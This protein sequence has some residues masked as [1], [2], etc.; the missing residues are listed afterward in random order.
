MTPKPPS[1][2]AIEP[3]LVAAATGDAGAA[4]VRRVDEH[5]QRCASCRQELGRYRAIDAVSREL[6][7]DAP[8]AEEI[9]ASRSAL[10]AR[11]ADLK[12]RVLM[13]GIV[14]SPLGNILVARSEHGVSLVE[15]LG[16][17]TTLAAS[18]LR[19]LADVETVE[20]SAEIARLR[21]DLLEF[22]AGRRRELGWRLDL[23]LAGSDFRRAV[24][25]AAAG[26]PYGAVTSYASI[27]R[28]VGKPGAERAV[29]Q[30]LRRNPLPIVVPCHRIVGSSGKLTGYAGNK[31][32][33]KRQLLDVEGVPTQPASSDFRVARE[34]MYVRAGDD[35]AYCLPT[36]GDLPA[37]N[38]AN[39]TLIA[40][41]ESVEALGL[42][43][44]GDCRPDLHPLAG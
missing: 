3:E 16:E 38:L 27:A 10:Q 32:G 5:T 19:E 9:A 14:P 33:L 13:Y 21:D 35:R 6:R 4:A 40:S 39:L 26:V 43:P 25:E 29:A 15:Y 2:R 7:H 30:A 12:S 28:R 31:L 20:S 17:A 41:R 24:L 22:L 37:H 8:P 18:R 42:E 36:C 44:C 34:A 23:R 11:L 1:C